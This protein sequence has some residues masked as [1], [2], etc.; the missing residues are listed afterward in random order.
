MLSCNGTRSL[1][2]AKQW[3]W[4]LLLCCCDEHVDKFATSTEEGTVE[5]NGCRF[6]GTKE[7]TKSY[8]VCCKEV[9]KTCK[10]L[11][12]VCGFT[13]PY[14]LMMIGTHAKNLIKW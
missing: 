4:H 3:A 9:A 7:V 5:R 12:S 11:S 2:T 10:A 14:S 13:L 8:A 1:P 6:L